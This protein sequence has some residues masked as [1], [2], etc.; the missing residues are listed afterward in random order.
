MIVVAI[1]GVLAGLA[2]PA[3]QIYVRR[4]ESLD[5]YLQFMALR[6]R[7]AAFFS[8]NGALPANF[9][10]LGL[11]PATGTAWGGDAGSYE[12]VFG[13]PSKVWGGVEYQPKTLAGGEETAGYIFVLRSIDE[14]DI[15]L[16][17]QIKADASAVR[18]RCTVNSGSHP[19]RLPYVPAS[20]R[21]GSADD[22]DW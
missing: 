8:A 13:I 15:G 4:A 1:I 11:P 10:D 14:P 21:S 3:Y 19:E 2:I 18:V 7:I 17:F 5:G 22:W 6:T 9:E 12:E 16:H 20:C